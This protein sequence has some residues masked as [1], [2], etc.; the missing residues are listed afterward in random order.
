MATWTNPRT[1]V[2]GEK[3]SAATFNQHVRD[4]F[5]AIGQ[6]WTS[7]SPAWTA[8]TTNPTIGNGS[9]VG[10]YIQAGKLVIGRIKITVGSTTTVGTGAYR[11]SIPVTAST[12]SDDAI[13]SGV[14]NDASGT[15]YSVSLRLQTS[16]T[17]TAVQG[18]TGGLTPSS[19]VV[20]ANGDI[21]SFQFTYEAA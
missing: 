12:S 11:F 8:A 6:A 13:G 14:Y 5:L 15:T 1:W 7:Y 21:Y 10:S 20:P 2:A 3:P 4:N 17:F 16:T 9:I 19:P 18:G